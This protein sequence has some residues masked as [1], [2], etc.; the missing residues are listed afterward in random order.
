MN[1]KGTHVIIDLVECKNI[2]N[3]TKYVYVSSQVKQILVNN[4]FTISGLSHKI[5][6]NNSF[7]FTITLEESHFALHTWPEFKKVNLD[8]YTCNYSKNNTMATI[9]CA[10]EIEDLFNADDNASMKHILRRI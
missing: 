8:I 10:D 1:G 2:E 5:F 7:T 6:D 3:L 4:G 9:K